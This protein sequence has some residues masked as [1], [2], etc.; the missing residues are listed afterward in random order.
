M[1]S[2]LGAIFARNNRNSPALCDVFFRV[3]LIARTSLD[4][5][6]GDAALIKPLISE[7]APPPKQGRSSIFSYRTR[8]KTF[9]VTPIVSN[10]PRDAG[11]L[12]R[13]CIKV[14]SIRR[15]RE[16]FIYERLLCSYTLLFSGAKFKLLFSIVPRE[17]EKLLRGWMINSSSGS[18]SEL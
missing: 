3:D 11:I 4:I 13:G 9:R 17:E 14:L 6:E 10:F 18:I 7:A 1:S 8:R 12:S 2:R 5:K 16:G 15:L